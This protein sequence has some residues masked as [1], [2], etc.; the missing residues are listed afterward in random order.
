MAAE[1]VSSVQDRPR[2]LFSR[3]YASMSPRLDDEGLAALRDELLAPLTGA[4]VEVGAGPGGN[5][6]RYPSAVASV[7]AVEPEPYLRRLATAAARDAAVPTT[8]RAGV[9]EHLPLPDACADGVVFC[10]VLCSV[11]DQAAAA[12][13]AARVLRPGGIVRF[14]E[15]GR[16]DTL[17]LRMLQRVADATVWPLLTGGCHTS[18]DPVAALRAAGFVV[19]DVRRLRFPADRFTQPSTPHVLGTARLPG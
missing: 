6:A 15:H 7:T 13:E 1:K 16:A 12:T 11:P 14:L 2:R 8:V 9:A 5:F 17:G 10:L 4:V 3:F 18:T 19:D